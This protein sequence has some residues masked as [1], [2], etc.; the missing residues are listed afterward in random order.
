VFRS[1]ET[2]CLKKKSSEENKNK[3][4]RSKKKKLKTNICEGVPK[5]SGA[6][7]FKR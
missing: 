6:K 2:N 3:N 5:K 4:C 1:F 7:H